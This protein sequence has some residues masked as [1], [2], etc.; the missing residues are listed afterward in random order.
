MYIVLYIVGGFLL[1][2]GLGTLIVQEPLAG[3]I[4]L[5]IL[6]LVAV[7][8]AALIRADEQ[9]SSRSGTDEEP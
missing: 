1:V 3:L 5:A 4:F 9:E 2:F 8:V 7:I 6:V